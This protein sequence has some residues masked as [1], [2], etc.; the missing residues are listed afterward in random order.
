[1]NAMAPTRPA[2]PQPCRVRPT[3]GPA[4]AAE[5][6]SHVR[7]AI[8]ARDVPAGPEVAVLFTSELVTNAIRHEARGT[9]TVAVT[10]SC[11]QMRVDARDT[12]QLPQRQD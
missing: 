8:C 12:A 4:A 9:V 1:M 6:R 5:A 10:C 3:T 11:D 7:V 2:E